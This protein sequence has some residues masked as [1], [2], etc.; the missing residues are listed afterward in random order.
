VLKPLNEVP[1][2]PPGETSDPPGAEP[3]ASSPPLRI[4]EIIDGAAMTEE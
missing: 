1:E 3:P 4:R 2:P